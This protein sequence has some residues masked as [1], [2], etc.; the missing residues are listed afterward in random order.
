MNDPCGRIVVIELC[1]SIN[2]EEGIAGKEHLAEIR[3]GVMAGF[4]LGVLGITHLLGFE[5]T[6]GGAPLVRIGQPVDRKAGR[7]S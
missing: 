1:N 7:P 3:P 4:G 2:V 5:E 6:L